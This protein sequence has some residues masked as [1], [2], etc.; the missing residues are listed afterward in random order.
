MQNQIEV[1]TADQAYELLK[2][3]LSEDYDQSI[4]PSS[5]KFSDELQRISLTISGDQYKG[6]ITGSLA[7]GIWEFQQEIYRAVA[8]GVTGI[9]DIRKVSAALGPYTLVFK[10]QEGSSLIE[11]SLKELIEACKDGFL[12]MESRHKAIVL[13]VAVIV[14]GTGWSVSS[15]LDSKTKIDLDKEKTAQM[16]LIAEASRQIPVAERWSKAGTNGTRALVKSVPDAD[17][18]EF[19]GARLEKEQIQEINSRAARGAS[20]TNSVSGRFRIIGFKRQADGISRFTLGSKDGEIP[21]VLDEQTFEQDQLSLFWLAAQH[22]SLIDLEIQITSVGGSFRG[23]W[24][25]D[26][27]LTDLNQTKN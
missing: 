9:D 10:V 22:D 17:F 4:D 24:V 3:L 12:T 14:L 26:I 25:S 15:V 5:L 19:G 20:E 8:F 23:A 18:I 16:S 7:R 13:I 1:S 27:P 21:V 2:K 11:A 6:T